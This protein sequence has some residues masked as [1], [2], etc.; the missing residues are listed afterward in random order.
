MIEG[1]NANELIESVKILNNK[2]V[3]T[4]IDNL[5]EYVTSQKEVYLAKK[6]ILE[7][8][9]IIHNQKLNAHLSI[10]LTQL[11]LDINYDLCKNCTTEI[12][13]KAEAYDIFVNFDMEDFN[14]LEPT[15][16]IIKEL[17]KSYSNIGTVIQSC[18]YRAENDILNNFDMRLRIVKGAYK[19]GEQVSFQ[20][21]K[22]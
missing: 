14:H 4:T 6:N 16:D 12:I 1:T 17:K 8:L 21:Q 11:G 9:E 18:L 2:N 3:S 20:N 7:V 5:G 13:E 22:I 10:K 15:W 19:E